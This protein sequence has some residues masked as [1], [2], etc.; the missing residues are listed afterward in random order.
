MTQQKEITAY[1]YIE[2]QRKLLAEDPYG[3][4]IDVFVTRCHCDSGVLEVGIDLL[5][6]NNTDELRALSKAKFFTELKLGVNNFCKFHGEGQFQFEITDVSDLENYVEAY[7]NWYKDA[8]YLI[9]RTWK[10][11]RFY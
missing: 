11:N 7:E 6:I 2:L 1:D 5:S 10:E 8:F 4:N 9:V 3:Y